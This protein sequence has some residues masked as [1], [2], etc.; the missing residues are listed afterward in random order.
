MSLPS[1]SVVRYNKRGTAEPLPRTGPACRVTASEPTR[2]GCNPACWPTTWAICGGVGMQESKAVANGAHRLMKTGGRLVKH[3]R[4][5][6]LLWRRGIC[7][8]V[9]C[10]TGS[11]R[12]R[13][14]AGSA[15]PGEDHRFWLQ[16]GFA[17][18]GRSA[19]QSA[20]TSVSGRTS[21]GA[22]RAEVMCRVQR[23]QRRG[24]RRSGG[25]SL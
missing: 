19:V 5:Y 10:C 11:G 8:S 17:G 13:C 12:C 23:S 15:S 4:Y 1:R 22:Y 20:Q 24:I 3:A 9:T 16:K 18:L 25:V 21:P 14:Q 2:Y 7:C 6:W